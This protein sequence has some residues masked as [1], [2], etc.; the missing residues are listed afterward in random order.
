MRLDLAMRVPAE[1]PHLRG[2]AARAAL[3]P[4]GVLLR[5]GAASGEAY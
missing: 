4:L 1:W 3:P 5:G 2:R